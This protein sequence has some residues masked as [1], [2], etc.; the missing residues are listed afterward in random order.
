MLSH[1]ASLCRR[2]LAGTQRNERPRR[3]D[4]RFPG[5]LAAKPPGTAGTR[6]RT[7]LWASDCD[8]GMTGLVPVPG[9]EP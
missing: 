8:A 9:A 4:Q 7:A 5:H 3:T 6:S 1:D 2:K